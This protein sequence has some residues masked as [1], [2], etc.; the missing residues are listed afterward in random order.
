[1]ISYKSGAVTRDELAENY[2]IDNSSWALFN[3]FIQGSKHY[4]GFSTKINDS[5]KLEQEHLRKIGEGRATTLID[6]N[7]VY[8]QNV[9]CLFIESIDLSL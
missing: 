7:R 6:M 2:G 9:G 5:M 4:E 1:M 3:I 8:I